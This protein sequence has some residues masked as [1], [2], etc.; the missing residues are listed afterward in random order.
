MAKK[1]VATF[2]AKAK[3]IQM[4]KVIRAV[5]NKNGSYSFREDIM[6]SDQVQDFLKNAPK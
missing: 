1:A 4:A 5:K 6:P 3:T 2:G